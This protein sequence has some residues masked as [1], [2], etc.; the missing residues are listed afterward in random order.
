LTAHSGN[1]SIYDDNAVIDGW[2]LTGS[3][4]VYADNVTI[5]N[6]R[7][8]SSNWWGINQRSGAAGLKIQ[9]V[10]IIG[11]TG[12]D[13]GGVDYCVSNNGGAITVTNANI[14]GCGDGIDTDQG[15]IQGNYIHD[16][17]AFQPGGN[18]NHNDGIA[19]GSGTSA[20]LII[21]DNTVLLNTPPSQ[22]GD[23]A[24]ALFTDSGS[25]FN[26]T[27]DHNLM[28]GGGY[29]FRGSGPGSHALVVTNNLF[30]TVFYSDSGFWGPVAAFDKNGTGNV[31]SGNK[32][33]TGASVSP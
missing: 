15:L 22:G 32:L 21:R 3:F 20:G 18:W 16:H 29:A 1:I 4:D 11:S 5:R 25:M 7:I 8:T 19:A 33:D 23:G 28:A 14:S 13:A 2:N 10:T 12:P 30:A 17:K 6:S 31:W 24:I 9:N 26:V 27:V